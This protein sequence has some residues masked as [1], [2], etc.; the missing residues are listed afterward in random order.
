[1]RLILQILLILIVTSTISICTIKPEMHKN[2]IVYDSA[3]KLV[4]ENVAK[5]EKE[6]IPIMEM[7]VKPVQQTTVNNY[8]VSKEVKKTEAPKVVQTVQKTTKQTPKTEKTVKKTEPQ[9]VVEKAQTVQTPKVVQKVQKTEAPKVVQITQTVQQKQDPKILTEKEE[10]VA[11]NL[12]RSNLTNKIMQ[13]T[14]LPMLPAGVVFRFSFKV[15]RYGKI[16]NVQTWSETSTYTPYAIQYIAP[17][18]RSYQGRDILNF[19]E[20]TQRTTTEAKGGWKISTTERYSTPQDYN[21]VEK[22]KYRN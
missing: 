9:K 20:G 7:P 15:D 8:T 2:V 18:I 17:V 13:D 3:Y 1:M 6:E 16:S 5:T 4:E 11:W 19:P 14:K 10:T 21:D 22:V 12:W